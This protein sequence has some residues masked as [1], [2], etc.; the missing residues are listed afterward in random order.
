MKRRSLILLFL[1]LMAGCSIT[2]NIIKNPVYDSGSIDVYFCPESDCSEIISSQ[3]RNAEEKAYC[4]FYELEIFEVIDAAAQS[5]AD[6]RMITDNSN[7]LNLYFSRT[8]DRSGLM[9]NKFCVID[10]NIVITGS[11][12]PTYSGLDN[13]NNLVMIE[14]KSIAEN[15]EAEFREMWHG[16]FGKGS[17]VKNKKI[18]LGN[19]TVENYFCP[20][21][22]CADK[23]ANVL[24]SANDSIHFMVFSF[25]D[26][27]IGDIVAEKHEEGIEILG[28]LDNF[29]N[30]GSKYSE[31]KKMLGAG[32]NVSLWGNSKEFLHHKVFIIDGK[33]VVTGSYN[34]TRNGDFVND[35]NMLIIHDEEIA[36]EYERKFKEILKK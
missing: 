12:N 1:L 19:T 9:H 24:I 33:M 15:Y 11:Y 34:P 32:I 6:V 18:V 30:K 5:Y 27:Y 8:D 26:D 7:P 13:E 21:D 20:E 2:G 36:K 16:Y 17:R 4:A 23:L 35:E 22:W 3:I 29:Q 10:S 25:T 14:S 31:Y 28:I